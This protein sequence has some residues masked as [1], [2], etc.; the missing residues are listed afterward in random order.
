MWCECYSIISSE[1]PVEIDLPI[2]FIKM[3][4]LTEFHGLI[5]RAREEDEK[6]VSLS[7]P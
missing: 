2:P 5:D 4:F 3:R 6:Y 7:F 1:K